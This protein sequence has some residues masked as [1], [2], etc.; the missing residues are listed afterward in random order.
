MLF[1]KLKI[2]IHL[3]YLI[4]FI[5]CRLRC[6]NKQKCTLKADEENFGDPC[7]NE[8]KYLYVK[9]KCKGNIYSFTYV[10]Q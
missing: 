10:I 1:A 6:G 9:Y 8:T 7:P 4:D 5:F 3:D 2:S